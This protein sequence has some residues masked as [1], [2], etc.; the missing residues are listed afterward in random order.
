[1]EFKHIPQERINKISFSRPDYVDSKLYVL[2]P[3]YNTPRFRTIWKNYNEFELMVINSGA[4]LV[5]IEAA[6]GDREEVITEQT[7]ENHTVI[8]VR[9][10][11]ELWLK[12]NLLNIA[13]SRLPEKAEYV[14]WVDSD[15][16][17]T[18]SDWV[19]ETIQLLQHY[20]AIQMF[21]VAIDLDRNGIP[22][23]FNRGFVY[24]FLQGIP[25]KLQFTKNIQIP[26]VNQKVAQ[27]NNAYC[28]DCP[29]TGTIKINYYHPGFAWA[30]RKQ[31]LSDLGGF[32]DIGILGSGDAH[33]AASLIGHFEET[34]HPKI[35]EEYKK[36]GLVWQDRAT[37]YVNQNI[38]FM[39]GTITH[40]FHGAKKNRKYSNRQNILVEHDYTPSTDIK[41][42][43]NGAY[44]LESNKP[45]FK[46]AIQQY[47]AERDS[48][49]IDM[50]GATSFLD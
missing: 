35:N 29:D 36:L 11:T 23:Q 26:N 27:I 49:N 1:M 46:R 28:D 7:S 16:K 3:V 12:E 31:V 9:T 18:R 50:Q 13:L 20:N 41:R 19:G 25:V 15:L 38:G 4:H 43:W 39:D 32:F 8:H 47:F 10:H 22:Y 42:G 34:I 45:A 21:R 17:F 48:D 37:K 5:S 40:A 33:M 14:C 2:S 44:E 30:Y 6:F 24:D